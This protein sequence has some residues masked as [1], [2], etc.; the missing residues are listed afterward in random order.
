LPAPLA[1]VTTV[2]GASG[3]MRRRSDREFSTAS[4]AITSPTLSTRHAAGDKQRQGRNP[5]VILATAGRAGAT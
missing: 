1:P 5:L 3:T 2:R 4:V